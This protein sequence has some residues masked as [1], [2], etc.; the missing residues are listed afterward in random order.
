MSHPYYYRPEIGKRAGQQLDCDVCVYGATAS[1]VIAAIEAKRQGLS[2]VILANGEH[3]GGLTTGGL[4]CTDFG[5]KRIVGGLAR[6]FYRRVGAHYGEEEEWMFEPSVALKV[7]NEMMREHRIEPILFQ[8][9]AST[10]VANK[11][12][13]SVTMQSGLVVTAGMFIDATYEGDLMA[14]AGVP[15]TVGRESNAVYGELMNGVQIREHHQFLQPISPWRKEGDPASGL[16]PGISAEPVAARGTGDKKVQAYNFRLCMTRA[17]NRIPFAKPLDYD[18]E[19]YTLL[20]R[21]LHAGWR[22]VFTKFDVI[23]GHKTDTNN[24]GALSTDFIGANYAYPEADYAQREKIFQAHVNYQQGLFWFYCHDERVPVDIRQ[25]MRR[26]GLAADE[27][28]STG[29]WPNQLYVREARRMVSD[30][31]ITE[32]DCRG[33]TESRNTICYGAYGMDSHNCQRVV[34]DGRVL[35]EGDVQIWPINPYPI[36]YGAVIPPRQSIGN[37]LVP[38]CLSA[39]HIAYGSVRMEPVFMVLG[40]SC[41]AAAALCLRKKIAVQDLPYHEL[42]TVLEQGD[43]VTHLE[44]EKEVKEP[45]FADVYETTM[46]REDSMTP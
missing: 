6:E 7:L 37:L 10:A 5:N 42:Q 13:T 43:Q 39:S 34:V 32:M 4:G 18:P 23:R 12:I 26:W 8:Y 9:L 2:V 41:A 40:Q 21:Y 31:V 29:N 44:S 19:N 35:N 25:K 30:T 3:I 27:F 1:G 45:V 22:D 11:T 15:Y 46:L 33:F 20:A 14:Q 24:H 38:I 28:E 36:P 17:A 16:L